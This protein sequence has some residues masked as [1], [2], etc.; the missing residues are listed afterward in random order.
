MPA[1]ALLLPTVLLHLT[2]LT[3]SLRSCWTKGLFLKRLMYTVLRPISSGQS[4]HSCRSIKSLLGITESAHAALLLRSRDIVL[5]FIA[6]FLPSRGE[7]GAVDADDGLWGT[8]PP[9]DLGQIVSNLPLLAT[10][11][12]MAVEEGGQDE[13]EEDEANDDEEQDQLRVFRL[14]LKAWVPRRGEGGEQWGR[15]GNGPEHG[16]AGRESRRLEWRLLRPNW[17]KKFYIRKESS[18]SRALGRF[19]GKKP[20]GKRKEWLGGKEGSCGLGERKR[21]RKRRAKDNYRNQERLSW[22]AESWGGSCPL[23]KSFASTS[24]GFDVVNFFD[25]PIAPSQPQKTTDH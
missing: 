9:L 19:S 7:A 21:R 13:A 18:H 4:S 10:S 25:Q 3:K 17:R 24:T 6:F 8:S 22:A 15:G 16:E 23:E 2:P 11:P 20:E 1:L 5:S 12:P 14:V